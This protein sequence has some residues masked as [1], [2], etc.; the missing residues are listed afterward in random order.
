LAK[1]VGKNH[2]GEQKGTS[3]TPTKMN[4]HGELF[5]MAPSNT[6]KAKTSAQNPQEERS[7]T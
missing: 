1:T 3:K 2:Q 6:T 4:T 7:S 5:Q